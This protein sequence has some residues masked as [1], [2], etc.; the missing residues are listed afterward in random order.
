MNAP[1]RTLPT[2]HLE[3]DEILDLVSGFVDDVT[4]E[5]LIR[6][7]ASCPPCEAR[8]REAAGSHERALAR[9]AREL[10]SAAAAPRARGFGRTGRLLAMAAGLVVVATAAFLARPRPDPASRASGE[11][12]PAWL[13]A[14]VTEGVRRAGGESPAESLVV[15]GVH[16]YDRRD[17][18]EAERLLHA[19]L[20]DGTIE[21][22]RR[23]YL[24]NTLVAL[25]RHSEAIPLLDAPLAERLPEP[26]AAEWDWT[27]LVALQHQG[28]QARADS[29]LERL[30]QRQDAVGERARA[31]RDGR[32][33][34]R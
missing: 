15:A 17:L 34:R 8:L 30:V 31:T 20:P 4:R 14:A 19:P 12:R 3:D 18:H 21:W 5:R 24:A 32:R 25:G 9:A 16:A 6:H 23:L 28:Q 2:A 1:P 10:A 7:V 22:M 29:V 33:P 11:A 13:P 27:L 26:W